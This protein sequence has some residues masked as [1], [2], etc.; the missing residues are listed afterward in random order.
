MTLRLTIHLQYISNGVSL[1]ALH[2]IQIEL[3][4]EMALC[5]LRI[6]SCPS[7][8]VIAYSR[9]SPTCLSDSTTFLTRTKEDLRWVSSMPG[10]QPISQSRRC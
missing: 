4:G 8:R 7:S 6:G 1:L 10:L 2:V 3:E 9:Y 5:L